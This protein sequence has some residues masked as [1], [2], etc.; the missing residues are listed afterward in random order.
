MKPSSRHLV[1][2]LIF[3]EW[4][5]F[6]LY[7]YLAKAVFATEFFP[8]EANNMVLT[9]A[10]FSAAYLARPI[11]AWLFGRTADLYGRRKPMLASAAL[12]GVATF[13]ICFLPNYQAVGIIAPLGLLLLRV[14]QGLALGGEM[15]TSAMYLIE[16][17]PQ[18][19]LKAGSLV[20]ISSALGM[21]LGGAIAAIIQWIDLEASWRLIF[22]FIGL[23]S[24][25]VSRRRNRLAESPE[26]KA[27]ISAFASSFHWSSLANIAVI[28]FFVSVCI[29]LCNVFWMAWATSL[30]LWDPVRCAWFASIAQLSSALLAY[31]IARINKPQN[32]YSLLQSSLIILALNA[33][34]LFFT[35]S[36]H[37]HAGVLLG[38][39]FY[40]LGNA[41][42]CSSLFYVLYLQLPARY[43]CRGVSITWAIAASIGT[44]C[45][46]IAQKAVSL[47]FDWV[48]GGIVS[49]AALLALAILHKP[50]NAYKAYGEVRHD[51]GDNPIEQ[52][53]T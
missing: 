37:M 39:G 20:A 31:P 32:A 29:Y 38:L 25:W 19:P 17:H 15:N 33:P 50:I 52:P 34:W 16:H 8:P 53:L 28:A 12:M 18:T 13:L 23:L 11:G 30:N 24:L 22:A 48:P 4:L 1:L 6:S 21:F 47:G 49:L 3:L 26:F 44:V 2:S 14:A 10:V 42:L 45:L 35:T 36:H 46:P 51:S 40:V 7:L 41:F 5:D 9:F 43:R 27:T